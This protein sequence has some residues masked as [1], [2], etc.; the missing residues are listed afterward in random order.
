[1]KI[2]TFYL[3]KIL[4]PPHFHLPKPPKPPKLSK[5]PKLSKLP[6]LRYSCYTL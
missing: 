2:I 4:S 3:I 5:F 6:T 1:M